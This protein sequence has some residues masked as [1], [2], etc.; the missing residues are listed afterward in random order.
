MHLL[1]TMGVIS[2][3]Q[4]AILKE[5]EHYTHPDYL[6]DW[7]KK[8]FTKLCILQWDLH[9]LITKYYTDEWN[10]YAWSTLSVGISKLS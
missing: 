3:S 2:V 4:P 6:N 8:T 9:E 7:G 1:L 10:I 5:G